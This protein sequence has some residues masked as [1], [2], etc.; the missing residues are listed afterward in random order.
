MV[1]LL[2]R[3]QELEDLLRKTNNKVER[4][5]I[6]KEIEAIELKLKAK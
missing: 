4:K 5:V 2:Q 3:I 6:L 1:N